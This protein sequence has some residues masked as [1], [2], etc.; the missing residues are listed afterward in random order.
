MLLNLKNILMH[1]KNYPKNSGVLST[2]NPTGALPPTDF[3][4]L[5]NY[6]LAP[7]TTFKVGGPARYFAAARDLPSLH[8]ALAFARS[9]RLPIKILGGGSNLL[10]SDRGFDGLVLKLGMNELAQQTDGVNTGT[11]WRAGAGCPLTRLVNKMLEAGQD[12]S[13][14]A[15]IPGTVGGAVRGNAGA[16]G[17]DCAQNIISVEYI[18]IEGADLEIKTLEGAACAFNYRQSIFKAHPEWLIISACWRA[19]KGN[20]ERI[21]A[22]A[23]EHLNQRRE[24]QP[25]EYPSAGSSFKNV[26]LSTL[27][28]LAT[29]ALTQLLGIQNFKDAIPAAWLIEQ[30]GLKGHI[31]GKAQISPKHSNFIV[32]LGGASAQDIY[33]LIRLAQSAVKDKFSVDLEPEVEMWGW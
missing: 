13:W 3:E 33:D 7:L 12:M 9:H 2:D 1:H 26:S 24:K 15:G 18:D 31:I 11:V 6:P 10:V 20:P 17:G 21:K 30:A 5:E 22:L 14:A 23:A 28:V 27:S 19:P 29:T 25:L 16:F 8:A 4:I 32:N